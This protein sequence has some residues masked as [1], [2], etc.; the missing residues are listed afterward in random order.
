MWDINRNPK[1]GDTFLK[2]QHAEVEAG[3]SS[4]EAH[5]HQC[6]LDAIVRPSQR[7]RERCP[8]TAAYQTLLRATPRDYL[9]KAHLHEIG[10]S[11]LRG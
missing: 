2:P 6:S 1:H 4:L 9:G 11:H 10:F 7:A 5:E 3:L 8:G